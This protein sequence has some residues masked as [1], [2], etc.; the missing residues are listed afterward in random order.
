MVLNFFFSIIIVVCKEI[1]NIYNNNIKHKLRRDTD[2]Y[3]RQIF[4][5]RTSVFIRDN[6]Y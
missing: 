6:K 2:S 3:N 1:R 5:K 4:I